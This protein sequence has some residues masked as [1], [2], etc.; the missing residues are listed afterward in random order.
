MTTERPPDPAPAD[1][2]GEKPADAPRV[3][4]RDKLAELRRELEYRRNAYPKFIE[5]G[6]LSEEAAARQ[7]AAL[8]AV[9]ADMNAQPWPQTRNLVAHWRPKAE[10]L[11]V[12]GVHAS[13]MH[14]DELIAV[15]AFTV[16]VM[17]K[18]GLLEKEKP[19]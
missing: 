8:E 14:R 6:T 19:T 4:L 3:P 10:T 12:L 11:T 2:F 7:L 5:R 13:K 15:L 9:Y 16:D 18:A 1:M 17:R